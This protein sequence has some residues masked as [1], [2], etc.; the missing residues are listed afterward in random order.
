MT[1][2]PAPVAWRSLA[3]LTLL[4]IAPLV[5]GCLSTQ[6]KTD[7]AKDVVQRFF[8]ALPEGDC[9]ELGPMLAPDPKGR[10][11][12]EVVA[13]Y[14]A[15]DVRLLS[16]ENALPDGRNEDAI[17]VRTRLSQQGKEQGQITV[18]R[19]VRHQGEWRLSP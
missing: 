9:A 16:V 5:C 14:N 18:L 10:S 4:V 7:A 8:A 6:G 1:T 2:H 11:C 12:E 17:M 19:V 3:T 13:E 15:H